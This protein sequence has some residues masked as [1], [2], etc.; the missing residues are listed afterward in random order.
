MENEADLPLEVEAKLELEP[1]PEV[2]RGLD[3]H[4]LW[5]WD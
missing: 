1:K 2:R 5:H 3:C 4:R